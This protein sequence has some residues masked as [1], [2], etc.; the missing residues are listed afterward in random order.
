MQRENSVLGMHANSA[1]NFDISPGAEVWIE[2]IYSTGIEDLIQLF[3]ID[4]ANR[5]LFIITWNLQNN[6][7]HSMF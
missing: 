7:E 4:D 3:I 5:R 6:R 2:N 1:I